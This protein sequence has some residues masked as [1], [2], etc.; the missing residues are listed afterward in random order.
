MSSED[1]KSNEA[2]GG[3][4]VTAAQLKLLKAFEELHIDTEFETAADLATFMHNFSVVKPK[5]KSNVI[6]KQDPVHTDNESNVHGGQ[7]ASFNFPKIQ[8]FSGEQNKGEVSWPCFKF[9]VDSLLA[10]GLFSQEQILHGIRKAAKGNAAESLR[11]LG[12][13]VNLQQV[14]IKLESVYGDIESKEVILRSLYNCTQKP[15]ESVSSFASRVEDLFDKAVGVGG[16]KKNDFEILKGVLYQGLRKELKH[17]AAYKHDTVNNYDTFKI[18]LRKLEL[19]LID[20]KNSET[21]PCKPVVTPETSE[22]NEIKNLLK[23]LNERID[24]IENEKSG[25]YEHVQYRPYTSRGERRGQFYPNRGERRGFRSQVGRNFRPSR[26]TSSFT[27]ARSC[28]KCGQ[29]GHFQAQCPN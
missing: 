7:F 11:R 12:V 5:T 20:E 2:S 18:E 25:K 1:L 16:V 19:D 24:K 21:K 9:E 26:P 29:T 23:K 13:G 3:T 28:H 15:N 17:M 22:I 4:E 27:F 6:I 14:L 10:E 8:N